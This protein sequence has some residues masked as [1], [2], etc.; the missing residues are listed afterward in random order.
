MSILLIC[1]DRNSGYLDVLETLRIAG[2]TPAEPSKRER[3]DPVVLS[4]RVCASNGIDTDDPSAVRQIELGKVWEALSVDL[5]LANMTPTDWGWGDPRLVYMLEHWRDFDPQV[6]FVLVYSSPEQAIAELVSKEEASPERVEASLALWLSINSELVRF[7]HANRDR[8]LLVN[9]AAVSGDSRF[10][11]GLA[12][13]HLKA[14]LSAEGVESVAQ[15]DRTPIFDLVATL[16]VE[17]AEDAHDLFQELESSADI[18][19]HHVVAAAGEGARHLHNVL[20]QLGRPQDLDPRDLAM[21]V[22]EQYRRLRKEVDAAAAEVEIGSRL[23]ERRRRE[24]ELLGLRL[25]Q[26]EEE[27]GVSFAEL[28]ARTDELAAKTAELDVVRS[29][30]ASVVL[31]RDAQRALL[32]AKERLVEE[33]SASR[34]ALSATSVSLEERLAVTAREFELQRE[35]LAAKE[36]LVE[37]LSASRAALS[38]TNVSLEERLAVAARELQTMVATRSTLEQKLAVVSIE[39]DEIAREKARVARELQAARDAARSP[40]SE[41]AAEASERKVRDLATENELLHMQLAQVQ[42][43]LEFYFRKSQDA[44]EAATDVVK[45]AEQPS[46]A[47]APETATSTS[48]KSEVATAPTVVDLRNVIDGEGWYYA[49]HDG[50]W[51]GPKTVSRLRLPRLPPGVYTLELDIVDAMS[52]EILRGMTVSLGGHPLKLEGDA[53]AKW[54][55]LSFSR[56]KKRPKF[57]V[58]LKAKAKIAGDEPETLEIRLPE[59]ISPSSRGSTDVRQLGIRLRRAKLVKTEVL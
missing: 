47:A 11:L 41:A 8:C 2:L 55:W 59:T 43:E 22:W 26:N 35:S 48:V 12:R 38:A 18:P 56:R 17:N 51:T 52:A 6:K 45:G 5:M 58:L 40:T 57:P 20:P 14:K 31:E 15:K 3:F 36:R 42:E 25:A 24:I 50:R 46:D 32:A 28:G 37:E 13:D 1:G 16:L 9:A 19:G 27:L 34:A 53:L 4:E 39:R 30:L 21:L 7:Y 49:E 54:G 10:F 33:L 44:T 23:D 29:E